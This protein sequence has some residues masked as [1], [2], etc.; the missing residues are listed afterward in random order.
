MSAESLI[1]RLTINF[2]HP[3]K[4]GRGEA[5]P[6]SQQYYESFV[7]PAIE[8]VF[9]KYK[10]YDL[11]IEKVEIDLNKINIENIPA[12]ISQL[13]EEQIALNISKNKSQVVINNIKKDVKI[14]D[15][16]QAF[17]YYLEHAE[18]PWYFENA[19]VFDIDQIVHEIFTQFE[20]E[21]LQLN[22]MIYLV[23]QN[24]IARQRLYFLIDDEI[25][26]KILMT[27]ITSDEVKNIYRII[28]NAIDK[29]LSDQKEAIRKYFFES[30]LLEFYSN[31]INIDNIINNFI[32]IFVQKI[33]S[34]ALEK[35]IK[36]SL[37]NC[38]YAERV[39][40]VMKIILNYFLEK[41]KLTKTKIYETNK[42]ISHINELKV[43]QKGKNKNNQLSLEALDGQEIEASAELNKIISL[44]NYFDEEKRIQ[45]IN[46]GLVILNPMIKY[47]FD[48]LGFIDASGKFKS[49]DLRFRAIHVLQS[50][51]GLVGKHYEH[52]MPL[53]KI[54]CG[55]NVLMP[56]DPEFRIKQ[57]ERNEIN[58]LLKAVLQHWNV[59]KSTSVKGLQESFIQRKGLIEKSSK[60]WIVRVENTGIDL[61]LDELPWSINILKYPWND[62]IIHV[63]WKH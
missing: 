25:L 12:C 9:E 15:K 42:N 33:E 24:K 55:L 31:K 44:D 10:H 6:L 1:N 21:K 45:I 39:E 34:S 32:N 52:L 35:T 3:D 28:A 38:N 4:I 19:D 53:N 63:E 62:Y 17:I 51:T 60:D 58:D 61:L 23:S 11:K 14:N 2:K 29:L 59:L 40:S 50:V 27:I 36:K 5:L 57:K 37:T 7:Y 47:L 41:K 46:A 16:F 48:A 8:K 30:L 18:I 54:I 49:E 26:N 13:L 56:V 20:K 22:E 43:K